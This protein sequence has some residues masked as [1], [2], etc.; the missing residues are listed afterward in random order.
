MDVVAPVGHYAVQLRAGGVI[1]T[2]GIFRVTRSQVAV[3]ELSFAG[4][5]SG[6]CNLWKPWRIQMS[7]PNCGRY[8]TAK[9]LLGMPDDDDTPGPETPFPY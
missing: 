7:M 1:A 8:A 6:G 4:V 9:T 5:P 2:S 3:V